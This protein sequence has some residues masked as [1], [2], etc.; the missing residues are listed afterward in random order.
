MDAIADLFK[1]RAENGDKWGLVAVSEGV[2]LSDDFI[3]QSADRDEFGHVQL[4]GIAETLAGEIEERTGIETRH[5]VL[6]HLQRGGTPTAYDRILSTRYGLKA[7]EAIKNGE[8]GSMVALRGDAIVTVPLSE[9][10]EETKNR[11]GQALRRRPDVFRIG[12]DDQPNFAV[13][14]VDGRLCGSS[15][16]ARGRLCIYGVH[17]SRHRVGLR[18]CRTCHHAGSLGVSFL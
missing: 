1:K 17:R 4:G 15:G 14:G 3:T 10:T 18:T 12:P 13:P 9:A 5:V 8:W 7:A 2:V 11:P 16:A 6:G